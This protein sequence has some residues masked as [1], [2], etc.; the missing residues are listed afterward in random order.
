MALSPEQQQ[1]Q[2]QESVMKLSATDGIGVGMKSSDNLSTQYSGAYKP[3]TAR[4]NPRHH[5][6]SGM[7]FQ[8]PPHSNM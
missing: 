4:G 3:M 2:P 7:L 8:S 1:Q 6:A 5:L